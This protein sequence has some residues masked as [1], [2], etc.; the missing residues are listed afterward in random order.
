[1]FEVTVGERSSDPLEMAFR[2]DLIRHARDRGEDMFGRVDFH[3]GHEL[4]LEE[5]FTQRS[6]V[7]P[8]ND[9]GDPG[10]HREVT[11]RVGPGETIAEC[12]FAVPVIG[13]SEDAVDFLLCLAAHSRDFGVV[14]ED[15]HLAREP[16]NERGV[17]L[18]GA[19]PG[20]QGF[21]SERGFEDCP[22]RELQRGEKHR[23]ARP[24]RSDDEQPD[25]ITG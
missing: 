14:L 16:R 5:A 18:V 8:V 6:S 10:E 1:M 15:Q 22:R 24:R 21:G 17:T 19:E 11:V 7:V 12:L 3:R 23:F 25:G 2:F 20:N 4:V 13:P 9:V